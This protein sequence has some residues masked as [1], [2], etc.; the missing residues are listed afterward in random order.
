MFK[1]LPYSVDFEPCSSGKRKLRWLMSLPVRNR[2]GDWTCVLATTKGWK[3][4]LAG[5][6]ECKIH[7][8]IEEEH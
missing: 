8:K 3:D 4:L 1:L 7:A 5:Q 2:C 6:T